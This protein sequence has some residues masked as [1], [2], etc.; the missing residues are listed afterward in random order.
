M[1]LGEAM[2]ATALREL[3]LF[4]G[5]GFLVGALDELL[6]DLIWAARTLWRRA[7]IYRRH[8]RADAGRLPPP[9][10][11]GRI[12]VFV[13]AWDESAVIGAMLKALFARF[14]AGDYR[15]YVGCYPNDAA[16]V[17]IV[18]AL[19]AAEPRLRPALVSAP[20]PSTKADCLN[21][22]WRALL[23]D[24][25]AEG[26]RVKAVL[27]HDAED[28]VHPLELVVLD[29]LIERFAL[30]QL[31]VRPLVA[32]QG[33]WAKLVSGHYCDEFAEGHGKLAVVREA[34][35]AA[36]PSAGVGCGLE[37]EALARIAGE[38]GGAPFDA[39]SLT[40]D[41][42]LGLRIGRHG[43]QAFVWLPA[44]EGKPAPVAVSAHFPESFGAAVRQKSRWIAG[45]AFAGWDRLGW[46]GGFAERW[47]RLR[48]RR[49]PIAALVTFAGYLAMLLWGLLG[50]A[51]LAG[52]ADAHAS[53]LPGWLAAANVAMLAW[54]VLVRGG[55]AMRVYGWRWGLLVPVR[56]VVANFVML[57]AAGLAF[58]RYLS[59]LR[60]HPPAWGKTAH[61]FPAGRPA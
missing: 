1:T 30:V 7:T 58:W 35:G 34:L 4:A 38:A 19:A 61:V 43:R 44:E 20:G 5:V 55:F 23:A 13:P 49:A 42:E 45:I 6:I 54:R 37:R 36:L 53:P 22:L 60:G 47:M 11:P 21:H 51:T 24:E 57:F 28:A 27:L 3:A 25:A 32:R 56:L 46:S 2:A 14:G 48:D 29:R 41:Y 12:A 33:L 9:L 10:R 8:P 26:K 31:P 18:A 50:T 59:I 16:T 39:G 17:G 52:L 15:V 40:E